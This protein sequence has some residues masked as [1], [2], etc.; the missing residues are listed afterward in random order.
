MNREIESITIAKMG[1]KFQHI[2][3]YKDGSMKKH[4]DSQDHAIQLAKHLIR[5]GYK[6]YTNTI[7]TLNY[8]NFYK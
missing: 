3:S 2:V 6:S 4:D 1:G 7:G 8:I 5:Q